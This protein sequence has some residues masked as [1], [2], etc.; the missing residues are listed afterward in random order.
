M[1]SRGSLLSGGTGVK[2]WL[3][4]SERL[5]LLRLSRVSTAAESVEFLR[6]I[7]ELARDLLEAEKADDE[8]RISDI[9]VV[10]PRKGALTQIFKKFKPPGTPVVIETL[11]E[12]V[13][14]IVQP[15]R[16]SGWQT[17]VRGDRRVRQELRIIL[18]KA[19]FPT[20]GDLFDKAYAYVRE[21][22]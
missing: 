7:L 14:A 9:K 8:G 21:N 15:V 16:G 19:G 2:V 17:S 5:E 10:D 20:S 4:L 12:K 18:N 11:V 3:S 22:Y 1:K 6:H 13:D